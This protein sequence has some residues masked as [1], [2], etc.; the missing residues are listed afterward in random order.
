MGPAATVAFLDHLTTATP[1]GTD[2]EH[3]HV[4]VESNPG[5]PDRTA[6]LLGRGP[7]PRP[8]LASVASRLAS[9]G[10]EI[11]VLPCNTAAAFAADVER[12]AGVPLID[13][14]GTS[15]REL[16]NMGARRVG[17]LATDGTIEAGLYATALEEAS[18]SSLVPSR[19]SQR[20]I[21]SV[22]YGRNGLKAGSRHPNL[23]NKLVAI[24]QQLSDRGA[25]VI[26]LACTELPLALQ[27][28]SGRW[29]TA[30]VDPSTVV[31]R[32]VVRRAF[33]TV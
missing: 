11:L 5:I 26:L 8:V 22:I 3:L 18:I 32:E 19:A 31:A 4:L 12:V 30:C 10:A 29:P 2:Q 33:A 14:I 13:W 20:S 15:V 9:A 6:F 7:D 21:M 28:T 27:S 23:A 1:A 17:L 16:A 24:A 25:D